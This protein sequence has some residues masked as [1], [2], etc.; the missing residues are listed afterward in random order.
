MKK[1]K[2][3]RF[4]FFITSAVLS[5]IYVIIWVI[6]SSSRAIE[7][8]TDENSTS[9]DD[10][11]K[12]KPNIV[13]IFADDVGTSDVPGYWEK[14]NNVRMPNLERLVAEGTTFTDAHSTPLCAPSRY[15]LLSGNYP[16]RGQK[17]SCI[18]SLNYEMSQFVPGQKSIAQVLKDNGY[19]TAM[20]GK[21]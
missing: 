8:S 17:D 16:H 4:A 2:I 7:S 12:K 11:R 21:W 13:V 5:L 6:P 18:W 20:F 9:G 14:A 15:T 10:G 19:Q 1:E 3:I